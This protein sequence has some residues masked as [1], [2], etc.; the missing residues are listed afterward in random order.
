MFEV[1]V[2]PTE[3]LCSLISAHHCASFSVR[4]DALLDQS[5]TLIKPIMKMVYWAMGVGAGA[6]PKYEGEIWENMLFLYIKIKA[7]N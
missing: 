3:K 7:L 6:P 4:W 1:K 2:H 5:S